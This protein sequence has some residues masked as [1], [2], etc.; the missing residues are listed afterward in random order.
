MGSV[1]KAFDLAGKTALVTGAS[2]GLGLQIAEALGEQGAKVVLSSRKA[3]DLAQAQ[4][5]LERHRVPVEMGPVSRSGVRGAGTS[6]YFRDPDGT[7]L[8]FISYR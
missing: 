4:E 8:E 5:H 2:R 7:L 3:S 1:K 6:V